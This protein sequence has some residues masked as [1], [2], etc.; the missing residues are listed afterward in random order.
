MSGKTRRI[1]TAAAA[2]AAAALV[3]LAVERIFLHGGEHHHWW[4]G[5]PLFYGLFGT[6]GALILVFTAKLLV[7]RLI[8][9]KE[10]YY[11]RD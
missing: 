8:K 3:F 4:E 11:D 1:R 2:I 6:A 10:G 7:M 5:I 9:R